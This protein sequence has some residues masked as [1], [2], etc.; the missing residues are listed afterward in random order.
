MWDWF[1]P[2]LVSTIVMSWLSVRMSISCHHSSG[3]L[4]LLYTWG[5]L[6]IWYIFFQ[7]FY[8]YI[9]KLLSNCECKIEEDLYEIHNIYRYFCFIQYNQIWLGNCQNTKDALLLRKKL[10]VSVFHDLQYV[11]CYLSYKSRICLMSLYIISSYW[12]YYRALKM[13]EPNNTNTD[14]F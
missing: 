2:A 10:S 11:A 9:L 4:L 7:V 6:L 13:K 5:I 3:R 8:T 12:H 1:Y 14:I